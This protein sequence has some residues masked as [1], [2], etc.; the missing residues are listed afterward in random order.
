MPEQTGRHPDQTES[1]SNSPV[2][3]SGDHRRPEAARRRLLVRILA[4]T[5]VV[6]VLVLAGR[7][8]GRGI[9]RFAT[10]VE[11]L[12]VW[13]PLVFIAGYAIATVALVPGSL[14][15]LAAGAIFGLGWGT[16]YV[17]VGATLGACL[18]FLVARHLAR[19]AVERRLRG[20]ARFAAV[21][22]AVGREGLKIVTLL[23]LAPI[24][25]F[26]LLNYG[27]GLTKVRFRDYAL[28]C[29][30]MLPATFLYVYYGRALGSLAAVAGG[31]ELE[32]GTGYWLTFALGLAAAAAVT[33]YVTRLARRALAEVVGDG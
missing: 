30:G 22:A 25:P 8:I 13:G 3:S 19:G 15:T 1:M 18:A 32:K 26:N 20:D 24:F 33:V 14:L 28:A 16:L 11:S 2:P 10:W 17:F 4:F 23:R 29:F 7:Q 9:P 12:G 31:V 5:L 6:V 27:L 21:D